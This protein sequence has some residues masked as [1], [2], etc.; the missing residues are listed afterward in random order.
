MARPG[1]NPDFH[2]VR[3]RNNAASV[4]KRQQDA[5]DFARRLAEGIGLCR[6]EMGTPPNYRGY[7]DWLN[8]HGYRMR[9]GALWTPRQVS[10]L[11]KRI[12]SPGFMIRAQ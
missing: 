4:K 10:K 2:R 11:L 5:D 1:G 6:A 12:T 8:E 3:N 7:A 9:R